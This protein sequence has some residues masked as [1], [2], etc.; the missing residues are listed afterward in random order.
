[1]RH[2]FLTALTNPLVRFLPFLDLLGH[3]GVQL[4]WCTSAGWHPSQSPI[5]LFCI[6]AG[7]IIILTRII[8][9]ALHKLQQPKVISEVVA[10]ILL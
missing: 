4:T 10:G 5:V 3:P 8:A 1:M 9:L 7:I 6:Q 2:P